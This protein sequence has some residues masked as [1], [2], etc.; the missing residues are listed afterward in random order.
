M[1]RKE[2]ARPETVDARCFMLDGL[3]SSWRFTKQYCRLRFRLLVS[4]PCHDL[5]WRIC[6][7]PWTADEPVQNGLG[8]LLYD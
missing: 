4:P 5:R 1:M 3:S 6:M 8:V 2:A 7:P